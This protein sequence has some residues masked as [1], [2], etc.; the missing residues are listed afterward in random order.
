MHDRDAFGVPPGTVLYF[1]KVSEIFIRPAHTA[2][3]D[4]WSHTQLAEHSPLNRQ[5]A[6]SI[7]TSSTMNL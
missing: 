1:P 2:N 6:A 7:P 3:L 5:V 4:N